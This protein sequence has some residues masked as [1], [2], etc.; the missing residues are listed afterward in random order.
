MTWPM[1]YSTSWASTRNGSSASEMPIESATSRTLSGFQSSLGPS[2]AAIFLRR[3]GG[4]NG[5]TAL[6]WCGRGSRL[7]G[8]W[9]LEASVLQG[10]Q[11]V[12]LDGSRGVVLVGSL[13]RWWGQY[14]SLCANWP[15]P[16]W[17]GRAMVLLLP[18]RASWVHGGCCRLGSRNSITLS[19]S[20][21]RA[22]LTAP[23]KGNL[24]FLGFVD[25]SLPCIVSRSGHWTLV[26][27]SSSGSGLHQAADAQPSFI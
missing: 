8:G 6:I 25:Y 10:P 15:H 23:S 27:F 19:T 14:G 13:V 26:S 7:G 9:N 5:R 3:A 12:D 21:Q 11:E 4:G 2:F 20:R 18:E 16:F 24:F 1:R 22:N 17:N